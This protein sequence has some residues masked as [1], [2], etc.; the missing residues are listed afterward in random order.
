MMRAG[1]Q[2]TH[3]L[4][5]GVQGTIVAKDSRRP[6]GYYLVEW[7]NEPRSKLQPH[8]VHKSMLRKI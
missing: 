4:T 8:S 3:R 5:H 6:R 7:Y 1:Q 2:V